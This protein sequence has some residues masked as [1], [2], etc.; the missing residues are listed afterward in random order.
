MGTYSEIISSKR[1]NRKFWNGHIML[2][3]ALIRENERLY[4]ED[5]HTGLNQSHKI[6]L[7]N[8]LKNRANYKYLSNAPA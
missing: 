4:C 2:K 5:K 6:G 3:I 7:N 8:A 1:L